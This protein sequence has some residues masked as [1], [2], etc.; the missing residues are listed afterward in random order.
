MKALKMKYALLALPAL[1]A[2]C[3]GAPSTPMPPATM[4]LPTATAPQQQPVK[5]DWWTLYGDAQL[6][7]LVAEAL[8]NNTDLAR[9]A[10]RIDESRALVR[11]ARADALPSVG[12][13]AG[14]ARQRNGANAGLNA[15][16][17]ANNFNLG[18]NVSWEL[19]LWGRLAAGSRAAREDLAATTLDRDALRT[20]LAAQ[21]VQ[22]Y[23][24]VQ[25]IDAQTLAFREAVVAQRDGVRL[26]RL[27]EQ[28][29]ELSQLDLRQIEAEL[30]G[31][32][33]QL[34]KLDR[35]RGETSR[36]LV[37]LLGRSPRAVW[38][39][40]IAAPAKPLAVTG[41]VPAGLPSTLL[42][43][44][45]D[46][47]AAEARLR[48]AG[49]RVDVARA[50]YLPGV[51]LSASLGKASTDLSNL[52][53]GP[54]T[55]W[56][57]VASLTQPI[58]NAG[59]LDAGRE[60]VL[61]RQRQAELD[62]RDAVARAFREVRD[63]LDAQAEASASLALARQRADALRQASRLTQL[64]VDA[65]ES[66]RLNAIEAERIALAAQSQLADQQRALAAAQADVF[67]ALGGGWVA[68]SSAR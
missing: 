37:V 56:S 29:G 40:A 46:V 23:A 5:A 14:A 36:A 57:L 52:L 66:S 13:T 1:L 68:E 30:A 27:R 45:P 4:E 2:A 21:V 32:E 12:A 39:A 10:A 20:A 8:A 47:A 51:A 63:A 19:D 48:A 54:S 49:A 11:L 67:R 3:A 31:N 50:A 33:S 59:R 61:A 55:I 44:R 42:Q 64:R 9:A 34:L 60:A 26:Q 24:A 7:A 43:Q 25:S 18:L 38:D 35:A 16:V 17:T 22:A 28:G 6:D 62:Y 15:P 65:G 41:G 58:W 53:D